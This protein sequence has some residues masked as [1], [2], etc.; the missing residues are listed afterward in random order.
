MKDLKFFIVSKAF[1]DLLK[2]SLVFMTT[3]IAISVASIGFVMGLGSGKFFSCFVPSWAKKASAM[4]SW[5]QD[6]SENDRKRVIKTLKDSPWFEK[7]LE[8]PGEEVI[9]EMESIARIFGTNLSGID[10]SLVPG[11]LELTFNNRCL[12]QY[13]ECNKFLTLLSKDPAV[14]RFYSGLN[15]A[16]EVYKW[17]ETLRKYILSL[18]LFFLLIMVVL[19]F[20]LTRLS[21]FRRLKEIYLWD[22]LGA[23]PLVQRLYCYVQASLL[24]I[25]SFPLSAF[26]IYILR[27]QWR[28]FETTLGISCWPSG[29]ELS[30][31]FFIGVVF[32]V[33]VIFGTVEW[34][35]RR[36]WKSSLGGD[37]TWTD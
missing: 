7:I 4:V 37:W 35:F 32:I 30:F 20:L 1:R 23:S 15:W 19:I 11:Y 33:L 13:D 14:D 16:L 3:V 6:V 34:A 25:T 26:L 2:E 18:G 17:Y 5:K 10:V 9:K 36:S 12:N 22:L 21:F 29:M 28:Y 31:Y 24:V 27:R 8:V